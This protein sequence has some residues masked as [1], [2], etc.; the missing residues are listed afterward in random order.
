MVEGVFTSASARAQPPEIAPALWLTPRGALML[1]RSPGDV[2]ATSDALQPTL[3]PLKYK[4][5]FFYI[6]SPLPDAVLS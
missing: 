1:S 4:I 6:F 5:S 3:V 2:A